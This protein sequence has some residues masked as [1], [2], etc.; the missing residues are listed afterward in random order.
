M[1]NGLLVGLLGLTA[2][3]TAGC[4]LNTV[5]GGPY[6]QLTYLSAG[7]TA[8]LLICLIWGSK[9]FKRVLLYLVFLFIVVEALLQVTAG[10]GLIPNLNVGQHVPYGRVYWT[11]E[12]FSNGLM[13]RYGW[14]YPAFD[15]ERDSLRVAIIG[16]SFVEAFQVPA[17]QN[18][19]AILERLAGQDR[20]AEG[21]LS[22]LALGR[23]GAGPAQY[24]ELLEYAIRHFRPDEAII[25][26]FLGNDF[27]DADY[28]TGLYPPEDYIYYL[29]S[30]DGL[31]LHPD[32]VAGREA[33]QRG[34]EL[35]HR[36]LL[37][38]TPLIL[39]DLLMT[40]L[41]ADQVRWRLRELR[42]PAAEA[43]RT[44]ETD[45]AGLDEAVVNKD[46]DLDPDW[47]EVATLA[48]LDRCLET[49]GRAGIKL[50]LVTIPYFNPPFY[51]QP[52]QKEW[53]ARVS[54]VDLLARERLLIDWAG[55]NGVPLLALGQRFRAGGDSLDEIK[56]FYLSRTGGGHFSAQGHDYLGRAIHE[57]FYA[58]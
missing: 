42:S 14:H 23:S 37:A 4:L 16:D 7:L 22:V 36:S 13:N 30:D 35:N 34:L 56:G 18:F 54:G 43:E 15:L 8:L 27:Q 52:D 9:R 39:K 29:P 57:N 17:D 48:L 38:N 28:R 44:A 25:A 3:I 1:I 50:R 6:A 19:A 58:D 55:K 20:A 24:L 32:S 21:R 2:L 33:Y 40:A 47:A 31:R 12:G 53:S 5:T 51:E 49:A 11:K 26:I 10:L 41:I 45:Q 46:A